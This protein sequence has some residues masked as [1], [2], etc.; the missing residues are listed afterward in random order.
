MGIGG[1]VKNKHPGTFG[2]I[3]CFSF[4]PLK[5]INAIGDAGMILQI[6]KNYTNGQLNIETTA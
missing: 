2:D 4:H 1:K 3:G 6:I 5:T